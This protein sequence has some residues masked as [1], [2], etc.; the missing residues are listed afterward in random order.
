MKKTLLIAFCIII[1]HISFCQKDS[2]RGQ[3]FVLIGKILNQVKH[4]QKC[5]VIAWATVV[6]FEIRKIA[7]MEYQNKTIGII[8]T[9]PEI[10]EDILKPNTMYEVDFSDTN[11]ANFS[12]VILKSELLKNNSLPFEPYLISLK[13]I[14]ID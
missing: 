3:K 8:S 10:Y 5:G 9:C 14:E 12:W 4:K 13:R 1:S 7:G 6:E 11:Q 2:I